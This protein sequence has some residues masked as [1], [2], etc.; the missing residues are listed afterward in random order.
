MR[1]GLILGAFVLMTHTAFAE[2]RIQVGERLPDL[3]L[4]ALESGKPTQLRSFLGKKLL[5]IEFASW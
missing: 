5:L 4:P 3:T 1:A 2:P